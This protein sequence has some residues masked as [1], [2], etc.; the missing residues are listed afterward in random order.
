MI[1]VRCNICGRDDWRIR[2]PATARES[3]GPEV[4]AFRCTCDG[5]GSHP[6]IVQ[7]LNCGYVYANPRW[8]SDELMEAYEA[9]KDETYLEERVG[10]ERTF[11][12]HLIDLEKIIADSPSAGIV[13]AGGSRRLLDVGAYIGVFVEVA[14]A[15]GWD[16]TGVEPSSWAVKV[17]RDIGTSVL[18]GTLDAPELAGR[19]F[20]AITMWDVI[21]HVADPSAELAKAY[22]LLEPGGI[23]A[24][25]TMDISSL[26]ARLMGRRWPWLMDMHLHYYDRLT[27]SRLLEAHGYDIIW[28]GTQGR[29][30]SLNY[31]VSRV[32]GMSQTLGRWLDKV[33]T[34]SGRGEL[35]I[36]V[37][38]GDLFTVV[39]RR[40]D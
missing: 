35:T 33:V 34:R 8:Q 2:F 3:Q 28:L 29:Y 24:I 5:Y 12:K 15:R 23:I 16:A 4:D 22:R 32:A 1:A 27:L 7:C 39:A 26:T 10:R 38:F 36:P 21:E 25:H 14:L 20:D 18:H 31:L 19:R 11:S 30:L 9:V 17:A 6:Q 13:A 40:P 37:N